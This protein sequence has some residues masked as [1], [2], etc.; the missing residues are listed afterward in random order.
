MFLF[1]QLKVITLPEKLLKLK[2]EYLAENLYLTFILCKKIDLH[3]ICKKLM[4][5]LTEI[6]YCL[7]TY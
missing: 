5:E 3:K 2:F 1:L 4:R 6:I 7:W